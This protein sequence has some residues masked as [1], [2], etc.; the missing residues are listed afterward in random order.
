[1]NDSLPLITPPVRDVAPVGFGGLG[2]VSL[3]HK[4]GLQSL[5]PL[6]IKDRFF[7]GSGPTDLFGI[8]EAVDDR[9]AGINARLA[10]GELACVNN[11]PVAYEMPATWITIPD[12]LA[13]CVENFTETDTF[14]QWGRSADGL[15]FYIFNN[16]GDGHVAA[17]VVMDEETGEVI[18]ENVWLSVGTINRNGSHGVLRINAKPRLHLFEMTVAGSGVGFCG[19]QLKANATYMNVTGS[20]DMGTTCVDTD[21]SCCDTSADLT[22]VDSDKCEDLSDFSLPALGRLNYSTFGASQYPGGVLNVVV[23]S[24]NETDATFFGPSAPVIFS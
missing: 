12:F 13:Q 24:A 18:D 22:L 3:K 17:Q 16:I 23:L 10:N 2:S 15:T 9:I 20:L 19:A 21:S 7:N 5:D 1:V 11:T 8:L 6:A 4:F 14:L